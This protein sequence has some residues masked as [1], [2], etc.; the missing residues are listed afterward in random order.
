MLTIICL[1]AISAAT[2]LFFTRRGLRYLRYFQQEEYNGTRFKEWFLEKRTFDKK[3]TYIALVAIVG[4]IFAQDM[5]S[6]LVI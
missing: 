5:E 1:T 6:C 2:I 4:T 3:G